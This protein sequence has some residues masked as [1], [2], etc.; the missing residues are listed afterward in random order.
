[1]RGATMIAGTA[2]PCGCPLP[3]QAPW[4]SVPSPSRLCRSVR[5]RPRLPRGPTTTR[6]HRPLRPTTR[7]PPITR[8]RR[9]TTRHSRAITRRRPPTI[10]RRRATRLT[11]AAPRG[12][13]PAIGRMASRERAS[14]PT[15]GRRGGRPPRLLAEQI[16]EQ[17]LEVA[18]PLFLTEGYGAT[19]IEAVA[20]RARMSKRT[21]YSRFRDK[22]E[23]FGA[24]VHRLVEQLRPPNTAPEQFFE[25]DSLEAILHRLAQLIL[26]A[27]LSSS[28]LALQRVIVA[29]ATRFPELA[30]ALNQEG[31]RREA[32]HR[33]GALLQ[34]EAV[35]G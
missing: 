29:E 1:M 26:R 21:V 20:K 6:H 16:P 10:R 14:R 27:A 28:A 19:S 17:I 7:R 18:T 35:A 32:I 4:S 22:A 9:A 34:R 2:A 3:S 24:V 11:T 8:R 13:K 33:I 15:Q 31:T 12:R 25:G 23:L 30:E 5:S